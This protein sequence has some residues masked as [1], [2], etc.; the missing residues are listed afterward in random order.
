MAAA[1]GSRKAASAARRGPRADCTLRTEQ[2]TED[3]PPVLSDKKAVRA[4][5]DPRT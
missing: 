3:L 1:C 2:W 5:K 4:E